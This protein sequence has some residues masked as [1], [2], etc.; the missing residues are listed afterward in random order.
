MVPP[1]FQAGMGL[2]DTASAIGS[3]GLDPAHLVEECLQ[4]IADWEG[5]VH[6]WVLVDPDRA[7][8]DARR[9]RQAVVRGEPVGPLHG[10]P[11]GVKDIVDVAGF[12]TRA[13][14]P[15]R[16][17]DPAPSDA[18]LVAR[19]RQAGAIVLGKTVTTEFAYIDPPPTRNPWDRHLRRTPGGS[20]SG[21]AV[22][23]ALGMCL[24]AIGSQTGGSLIRPASYCGVA[25]CKPSFGRL[26]LEG[27][28]PLAAHLDHAGVIARSAA[29]CEYLVRSLVDLGDA[30]AAPDLP[31]PRLGFVEPFFL[32]E[33]DEL[34]RRATRDA[35]ERLAAGGAQIEVVG[36]PPGFDEVGRM[37]RRIMAVEAAGVHRESFLARREAFGPKLTALIDEGLATAEADYAAA[38]VHQ[39]AFRRG[40]GDWLARAG[41]MVMPATDTTAPPSLDT[42]G[43]AR[44]QLP[45]SYA[46]VPA[47]C[48][49]CGLAA[50]EMPAG[51]QFICPQGAEASLLR[52][53]R[54]CERRLDF[55][56]LPPLLGEGP[57]EAES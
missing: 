10:I 12:P 31:P 6:A 23:V 47:V 45:W 39:R 29:D 36:L 7:L 42:T 52:I 18:P 8:E 40:I 1:L 28:V 34:I 20:S 4:R 54:W 41:A 43:D 16:P 22:S 9:K 3:G 32:D 50:D 33:A 46:G 57:H 15:L 17:D 44:F 38:L 24:G 56:A 49:P 35:V 19:L 53:A 30:P 27:V 26:P 21:S 48:I 25:A 13:G 5:Q 11:L 37:H 2:S 51:L 14:S 55:R